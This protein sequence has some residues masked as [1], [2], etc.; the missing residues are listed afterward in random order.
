MNTAAWRRC[1][2]VWL[3]LL[4]AACATVPS[5]FKEP[6][7]ALVSIK[8]DLRKLLA[9]E[10][11]VVLRVS[12]PNRK[13]LDVVGLSYW[14]ELQGRRVVRGVANDIPVIPAYGEADVSLRARADLA[15]SFAL[16]QDLL[17]Q[18][19]PSVDFVLNADI[20]VGAFYPVINLRESGSISLR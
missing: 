5:D 18:V 19:E 3:L 2:L 20:D 10:F 6:S 15:G 7:V 13:A 1:L 8:P 11:E 9:P 16:V 17:E 12:N 14:V 4:P